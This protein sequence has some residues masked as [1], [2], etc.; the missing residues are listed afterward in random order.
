MAPSR[1]EQDELHRAIVAG[2]DPT[3]TARAFDLLLEPLQGRLVFRWPKLD[4]NELEGWALD[5]LIAYLETPTRYDPKQSALLT[6]LV[7]DADGDIK[8]AYSSARASVNASSKASKTRRL[9]G[10]RPKMTRGSTPTIALCT[11]S[12]APRSLRS[13]TG[14]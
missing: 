9:A 14:R 5:A 2:N 11:R 12:S 13:V 8:N 6:Y 3:A 7:M 10:M 4:R 1:A